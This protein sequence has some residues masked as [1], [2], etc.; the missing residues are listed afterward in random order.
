MIFTGFSLDGCWHAQLKRGWDGSDHGYPRHL[1]E[2]GPDLGLTRQRGDDS[3][4]VRGL[5]RHRLELGSTSGYLLGGL[6]L[7]Q[8]K[9]DQLAH[10]HLPC[11]SPAA[12]PPWAI[13]ATPDATATPC[14]APVQRRHHAGAFFHRHRSGERRAPRPRVALIY[15]ALIGVLVSLIRRFG[16][17]P[18]AFCLRR[19]AGQPLRA[20]DRQPD[21][22]QG[23][24]GIVAK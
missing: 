12:L 17:Y 8:Q 10:S 20:A 23:L 21:S 1:P 7:L 11:R 18:D 2:D 19:V 4:R 6:F 22:S 24:W 9:G 3:C 5:G 13:L 15:G 14:V 16:G